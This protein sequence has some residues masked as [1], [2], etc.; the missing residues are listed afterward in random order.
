QLGCVK[1]VKPSNVS[2]CADEW[3]STICVTACHFPVAEQNGREY[4][5]SLQHRLDAG[6][7]ERMSNA[8]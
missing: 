5:G 4:Y 7:A 3:Q 6:L 1:V 8:R 2:G